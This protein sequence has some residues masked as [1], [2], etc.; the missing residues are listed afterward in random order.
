MQCNCITGSIE[1][2]Q[3][4]GCPAAQPQKIDPSVALK[5]DQGMEKLPWDLLPVEATEEMLKILLYGKRKYSICGE[6]G[7]K[8]YKNP[9][10]DG[11]PPSERCRDCGKTNCCVSGAENWRK[12]F[13]WRR[14]I[15]ASFRHLK[16]ILQGIDIDE[17]SGQLHSGHLL[18][19]ASF[20]CSHQILGLGVDDRYKKPEKTQ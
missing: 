1:E 13:T 5:Y 4:S 20:L 16:A 8:W 10:L 3:K 15:A 2:H 6:C 18:C 14:L 11:D 17:E 19:M 9:R 12:G 7:S